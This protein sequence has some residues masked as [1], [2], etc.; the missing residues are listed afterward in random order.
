MRVLILYNAVSPA[1]SAADRDVLDQVEA[2]SGALAKLG[3][4]QESLA[5]TLDLDRTRRE[6]LRRRPEVV[7]NLVECLGGSDAL[8]HLA[9]ALLEGLRI[10]YTGAPAEA[11]CL[12]N[13]KLATKQRLRRAGLPTPDWFC[14]QGRSA[15]SLAHEQ[16]G[17]AFHPGEPY[18]LKVALEHA[19]FALEED[20]LVRP[21]NPEVLRDLVGAH[22]AR[23][24]RPCYAERYIAGREFNI[25][26]LT[27]PEGPQ[28]LPPAEVDFSAFP[29]GKPQIVGYRAKWDEQS[30]EFR[31][32]PHRFEFPDS[33]RPLLD[34]LVRLSV[35]CWRL[36]GLRGY[37]R[38]DFRV[39]A[40]GQPWI[41]EV[42]ANP[43]L[44]PDG[45][46]VFALGLA[47]IAFEQAIARIIADALLPG[48]EGTR[49]ARGVPEE[50]SRPAPARRRD[51]VP[52]ARGW[53][54]RYDLRPQDRHHVRRIV[55]STGMFNPAEV[56]LAVELAEERL[57]RGPASG[58]NFV[59]AE[60][61]GR[62]VGY[63]CY[64]PIAGTA[65]S[66]DLYWIAVDNSHRGKGLGRLL[67]AEAERL[68]G[69]AGGRRVYVE[70]SRR[71]QYAPTRQFYQRCGYHLEATLKDFY[72]PGD[73]KAIYVKVL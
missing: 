52:P 10:P 57:T 22:A 33:D 68:I 66:Y 48:L 29:P 15:P 73:D 64:G 12:T 67:L 31:Y 39:D 60:R 14:C 6:L 27:G 40:A 24:D 19:S 34:R 36:F 71:D 47:G 62:V 70:T 25:T 11:I 72:A 50:G 37:G 38:V 26:M 20:C 56:G 7:F 1:D 18:L 9:P 23:L 69:Q 3:D 65:A 44:S 21:E 30:F 55:E 45:G 13:N 53:A 54:F 17:H 32:T 58:Y 4:D 61:E 41:L 5:C 16:N 2:V 43:C 51:Q 8:A 35:E 28:V 63:V 46:F 42:N 59:F 49:P